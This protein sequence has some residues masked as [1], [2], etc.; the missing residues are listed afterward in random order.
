MEAGGSRVAH[1]AVAPEILQPLRYHLPANPAAAAPPLPLR[2]LQAE[3]TLAVVVRRAHSVRPAPPT[4]AGCLADPR[5]VSFV[6]IRWPRLT[7]NLSVAIR[8]PQSA[9]ARRRH[10]A[11]VRIRRAHCS[12]IRERVLKTAWDRR[13]R[14]EKGTHLRPHTALTH[15]KPHTALTHSRPHTVSTHLRPHIARRRTPPQPRG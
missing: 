1:Q 7:H 12:R 3:S 14:T 8:W 10:A 13:R 5:W 2:T 4:L 11:P 15:L 9:R 6:A